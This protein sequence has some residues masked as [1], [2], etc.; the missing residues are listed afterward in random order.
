MAIQPVV[1]VLDRIEVKRA[2]MAHLHGLRR[3]YKNDPEQPVWEVIIRPWRSQRSLMQNRFFWVICTEIANQTGIGDKEK[4]HDMMCYKFLP[5]HVVE[6][7]DI[8]T[9]EVVRREELGRTSEQD[10][11]GMTNLITLM[12]AYCG[13]IGVQI[14]DRNYVGWQ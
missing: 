8:A 6:F 13:E 12:L 9:G 5:P 11:A 3:G 2:A 10:T 14:E 7:E 4:V 1:Y